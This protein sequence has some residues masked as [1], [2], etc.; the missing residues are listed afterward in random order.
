MAPGRPSIPMPQEQLERPMLGFDF[1]SLVQV[2]DIGSVVVE[3]SNAVSVPIVGMHNAWTLRAPHD[4]NH[5]QP[6]RHVPHV[7]PGSRG[8]DLEYFRHNHDNA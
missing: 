2:A 5:K 8:R 7:A 4:A 3:F 6:S 1:G